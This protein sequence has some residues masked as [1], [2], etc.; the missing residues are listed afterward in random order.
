MSYIFILADKGV[1][2]MRN[3]IPWTLILL[4]LVFVLKENNTVSN[5]FILA[6]EGVV[7]E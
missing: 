2:V 5:I 4:V 7:V 3:E 6:D 1:V